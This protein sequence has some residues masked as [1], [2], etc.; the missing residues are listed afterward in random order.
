MHPTLIELMFSIAG[1]LFVAYGA[2]LVAALW[3]APSMK[4][5]LMLHPWLWG[6]LPKGKGAATTQALFYLFSGAFFA[7]ANLGFRVI[8]F[9]LFV[10]IL[11]CVVIRIK[12][13]SRHR[14]A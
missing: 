5:Y 8:S 11:V 13:R 4:Q 7:F 12:Q 10:P 3:F 1:S 6:D 14:Q 9:I 2:V